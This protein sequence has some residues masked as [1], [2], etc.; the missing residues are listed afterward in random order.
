MTAMILRLASDVS[1]ADA[2]GGGGVLLDRAA[3]TYWELNGPA[4]DVVRSIASTQDLGAAVTLLT[5]RYDVDAET[6]AR[7]VRA[8][9]DELLQAGLVVAP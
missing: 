9:A 8:L 7:D 1:F 5:E 3:G 2:D 4:C 6:A